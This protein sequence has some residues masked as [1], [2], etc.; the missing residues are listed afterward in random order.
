MDITKCDKCKK[1]KDIKNRGKWTDI[2]ISGG[3]FSYKNFD[4][5]EQCGDK[6]VKKILKIVSPAK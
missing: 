1:I 3:Y 5:C 2:S 6:I 4:F